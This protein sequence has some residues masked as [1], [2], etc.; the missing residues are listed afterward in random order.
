MAIY[1]FHAK[2]V[3]RGK[4]QSTVAAAAYR[5]GSRLLEESTGI[6][7]DYTHKHGV[8]H[9][10]ILAPEDAPA[11]VFDRH[12]LWNTVE[13]SE[14]RKDAQVAREIVLALPANATLSDED[15]IALAP[16]FAEQLFVVKEL[17]E[18][19]GAHRP[20][21]GNSESEWAN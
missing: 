13:A 15:R 21:D 16:S 7:H 12:T 3:H 19:L 14:K 1:H 4:G 2:M 20:H 17:A 9:S 11:W 6:T 10:E 5:S 18:Q 8:E